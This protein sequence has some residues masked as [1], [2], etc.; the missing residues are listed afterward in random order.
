MKQFSSI[1]YF[2]LLMYY[3]NKNNLNFVFNNI[4]WKRSQLKESQELKMMI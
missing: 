1:I 3:S 2:F 4:K